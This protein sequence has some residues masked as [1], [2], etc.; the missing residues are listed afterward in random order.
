MGVLW[1]VVVH[2]KL[3]IQELSAAVHIYSYKDNCHVDA[4]DCGNE[5]CLFLLIFD[6]GF[7]Y[8]DFSIIL[9]C[10]YQVVFNHCRMAEDHKIA[11]LRHDASITIRG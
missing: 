11:T 4:R 7:V 5:V 3:K 10:F 6:R 8:L 1:A 9:L 2:L